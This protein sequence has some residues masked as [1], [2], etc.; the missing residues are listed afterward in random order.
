M[1]ANPRGY[2]RHR[3]GFVVTGERPYRGRR[4]L[5]GFRRMQSPLS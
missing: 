4:A 5:D 2:D 1:P 3:F